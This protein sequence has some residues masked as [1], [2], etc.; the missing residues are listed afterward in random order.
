MLPPG[1]YEAVFEAKVGDTTNPGLVEGEWVMRCQART[2][3]DIRAL[4]GND[5]A[6]DRRFA[7]VARMSETNLALYRMVA[8]PFV[9]ACVTAPMA[10]WM[11]RLNPMEL[12]YQLFSD[13]NPFM[14]MVAPLA[15]F[16]REHRR[17]V[18]SD[19]P[20][21]AMQENV[22]QQI[23]AALDGW[24]DLRDDLTEV[25]FTA[26]YGAP[27]VQALYGINPASTQPLRKA[28]KS[29]LHRELVERRIDELKAHIPVGG[30]RE[31]IIR[32]VLYIGMSR[33]GVDERGFE[34]V[35]RV[36]SAA[37]DMPVLPLADFKAL[38][39]EQF[40]MLLIDPEQAI[41]TLPQ[42]LPNDTAARGDGLAIIHQVLAASGELSGE[43]AVRMRR[44]AQIFEPDREIV[45]APG[46]A[47][48]AAP[49]SEH[50]REA[51]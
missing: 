26:V 39:R 8:Q 3:D 49:D 33:N 14:T 2:L 12:K 51:S 47:Q 6:D 13:E 1:L 31:A 43:T 42:M 20:F 40:F 50:L 32:A 10:A 28:A 7:A 23:I 19:N 11:R 15:G 22:S 37:Q 48:V 17:A 46:L 21:V 30:L 41:A 44:I 4:G 35:R 36:R 16:V 38:V 24:R 5:V 27:A 9:R 45:A 18:G 29:A 34:A 25:I